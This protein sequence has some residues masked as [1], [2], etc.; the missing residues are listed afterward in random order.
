MCLM[1]KMDVKGVVV[2]EAKMIEM[3]MQKVFPGK[4]V[5]QI[6]EIG[7][8]KVLMTKGVGLILFRHIFGDPDRRRGD[9][10]KKVELA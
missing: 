2:M 4:S 7:E 6:R 10:G 8:K 9:Y 3:K 5:D 1:I